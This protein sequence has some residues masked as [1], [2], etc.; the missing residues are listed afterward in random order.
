MDKTGAEINADRF[1]G[2]A[3]VYDESRP[4]MPLYPVEVIT[5]YLGRKPQCVVDL[6]CGTGLSTMVWK[7]RCGE[8]VGIEPSAVML[9]EAQKKAEGNITFRQGFGHDTGLN[10]GCADAVVCSQSFHWMEP[11]ATLAEI[12]RILKHDG[13]FATVDCDWP[14]VCSW[15]AEKAFEEMMRAVKEA[16]DV[17]PELKSSFRYWDKNRHLENIKSSGYFRYAREIVFSS[18]EACD[19]ERFIKLVISQGGLQSV[20]KTK[21]EIIS[22]EIETF[23]QASFA[24]LGNTAFEVDFGYRMRIGVK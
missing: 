3:K 19:A 22:R 20:L 21:P 15:K 18:R 1:K 24:V 16:E 11:G 6:G 17:C 13:I 14:P 9:A 23:K 5:K 4:A 8:A 10:D 12:N 7:D 2:F